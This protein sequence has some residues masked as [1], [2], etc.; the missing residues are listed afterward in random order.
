MRKKQI[1][2]LI[3]CSNRDVY[4]YVFGTVSK[5]TALCHTYTSII[6]TRS[7][8]LCLVAWRICEYW[9]IFES[10]T[11]K[12]DWPCFV[13]RTNLVG[14]PLRIGFDCVSTT[15]PFHSR[16]LPCSAA[17][18]CGFALSPWWCSSAVHVKVG[19]FVEEMPTR[20]L[21]TIK[22]FWYQR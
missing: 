3:S 21:H 16:S 1:Q 11:A 17:L 13:L 12:S 10:N 15:M 6:K 19:Y 20:F 2:H 5:S 14:W 18:I 8:N 22:L 4:L 9:E 7:S